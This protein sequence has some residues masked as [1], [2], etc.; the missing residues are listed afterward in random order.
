MYSYTKPIVTTQTGKKFGS[1]LCVF[2]W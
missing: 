1:S 2:S